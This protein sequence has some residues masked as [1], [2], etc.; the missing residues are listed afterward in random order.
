MAQHRA[1]A[2]RDVFESRLR[3]LA[4]LLELTETQ[5][6]ESGRDVADIMAARLA[7]DM[8]PFPYQ[9]VFTC[10]QPNAFASWCMNR[11]VPETDVGKLSFADLRRHVVDAIDLLAD[12]SAFL[13]DTVLERTKR[14]D[15]QE[16]KFLR[17]SG[18]TYIDDWL[19]PNF[20]FHLVT[21]YD[22]LRMSGVRIGKA[23]YMVHLLPKVEQA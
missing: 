13:D 6:H 21:T 19:V 4:R 18:A 9:V 15:L 20:Y 10:N 16:G 2:T 22:L 1:K 8:L 11:T 14:I 17:L 12:R 3:M 23:D 7:D 5:F